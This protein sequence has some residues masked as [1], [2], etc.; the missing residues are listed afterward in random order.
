MAATP[1]GA[2]TAIFLKLFSRIYLRNVVFPVPAL[3]VKNTGRAVCVTNCT[4]KA[5]SGLLLSLNIR[6]M[7]NYKTNVKLP[8]YADMNPA[9]FPLN[10]IPPAG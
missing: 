6:E 10:P 4:A 1:V 3:P 8:P 2:T 9:I 5:N 7:E